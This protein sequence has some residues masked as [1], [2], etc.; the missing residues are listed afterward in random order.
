MSE[1]LGLPPEEAGLVTPLG[2]I[3]EQ[4]QHASKLEESDLVAFHH[5]PGWNRIKAFLD[6]R[7]AEYRNPSLEAFET[8]NFEDI[9][10]QYVTFRLVADEL[11]AVVAQMEA[12][13][14]Q[15]ERGE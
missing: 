4:A 2:E 1:S 15:S 12:L 13:Y 14:E 7:I 8:K 3:G 10:K 6:L 11:T 9:G 5:H